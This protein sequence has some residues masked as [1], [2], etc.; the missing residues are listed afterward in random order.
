MEQ[1]NSGIDQLKQR[2]A[3]LQEQLS[4][5]TTVECELEFLQNTV[6]QLKHSNEELKKEQDRL[7]EI[8][9]LEKIDL[10]ERIKSMQLTK[11]VDKTYV[12]QLEMELNKAR[13]KCLTVE[14]KLRRLQNDID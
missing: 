11:E 13:E 5:K 1:I 9:I 3:E 10:E 4:R 8:G 14:G 12:Q 7:V 2:N 6:I